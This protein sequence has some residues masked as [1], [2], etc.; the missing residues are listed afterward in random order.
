MN[1]ILRKRLGT[2]EFASLLRVGK[3]CAILEPPA[4]IPAEHSDHLI[5]LGYM[6]DLKG[7]LRMTSAGRRR[8]ARGLKNKP[9]PT[10]RRNRPLRVV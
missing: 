8:I 1:P 7:R 9:V 10:G 6:M 4:I 3:T 5:W 2:E